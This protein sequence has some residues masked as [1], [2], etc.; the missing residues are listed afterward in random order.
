MAELLLDDAL[1]GARTQDSWIA[2]VVRASPE[3]ADARHEGVVATML[4]GDLN[5]VR[6]LTA[7]RL[8]DCEHRYLALRLQ[9]GTNTAEPLRRARV[10][11]QRRLGTGRS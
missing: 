2:V 1:A 9:R 10:E 3:A 6:A 8:E 4:Y 7:Q 5:R 11:P